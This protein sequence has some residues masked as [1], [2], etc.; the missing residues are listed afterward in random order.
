MADSQ[1]ASN[2]RNQVAK[3]SAMTHVSKQWPVFFIH[4][5]PVGA[6]KLRIVEILALNAPGLVKDVSPLGARI[7][8]NFHLRQAERA[9]THSD[10]CRPIGRNC[11]PNCAAT[12]T[13]LIKHFLLVC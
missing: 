6:M 8:F 9:V 3:V 10:G 1:L 2:H 5:L 13:S 11:S 12:R 4:S 7:D